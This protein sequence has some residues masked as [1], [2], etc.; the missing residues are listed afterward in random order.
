MGPIQVKLVIKNP[1]GLGIRRGRRVSGFGGKK[2]IQII[3]Q[4]KNDI[5]EKLFRRNIEGLNELSEYVLFCNKSRHLLC[6]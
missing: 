5:F 1:D 2:Y 6:G 3:Q 4:Q